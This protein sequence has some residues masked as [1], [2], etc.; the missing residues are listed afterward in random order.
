MTATGVGSLPGSDPRAAVRLVLAELPD[1]PH[2]PELP[3]RGPGAGLT[4]RTGALLVDLHVDLQPSGW[5]LVDRAGRDERRAASWLDEDLDALEDVAQG[6]AGQLKVQVTGP[7]TL[8]ATL[9]LPQ[10]DKA[11]G[12]QGARRDIGASLVEAVRLHVLDVRRR[13]AG[14]ELIVQLDEPLLPAVLGGQVRSASGYRT[15]AA[16]D[17]LEVTTALASLAAMARD[18]G[19]RTAVHCCADGVPV[20]LLREA[21]LDA[22]SIDATLPGFERLDEELGLALEAGMTLFLGLLPTNVALSD[23]VLSDPG[24]SLAPVHTLRRRL[25]LDAERL[26]AAVVVTPTCGL[27][28]VS[29]EHARAVLVRARECAQALSDDPEG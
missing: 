23:P 27:A 18:A 1:L 24:V 11:L 8:A 26:A 16:L 20:A 4:G 7:F 22:L 15:L 9:D 5:R 2:L 19:A 25:G 13:V 10:G 12:D 21:G 6:Y 28:G 17:P 3:G 29:P 14:A